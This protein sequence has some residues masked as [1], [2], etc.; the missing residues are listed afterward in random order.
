MVLF[1]DIFALFYNIMFLPRDISTFFK[2]FDASIVS[3]ISSTLCF[4]MSSIAFVLNG[5]TYLYVFY[6][7]SLSLDL[8]EAMVVSAFSA[9]LC[10]SDCHGFPSS[11]HAFPSKF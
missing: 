3:R 4:Q 1:L 8:L 7:S 9:F 10:L 5:L 6:G 11:E 2:V